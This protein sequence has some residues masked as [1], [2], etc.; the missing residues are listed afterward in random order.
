ME[1][2]T[3]HHLNDFG[4]FKIFGF[5]TFALKQMLLGR[6]A[7]EFLPILRPNFI[8]VGTFPFPSNKTLQRCNF[9]SEVMSSKSF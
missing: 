8:L 2:K 9:F 5:G 7:P 3:V 4:L 1:S 6:L